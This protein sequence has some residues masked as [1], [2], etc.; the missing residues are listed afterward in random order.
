MASIHL[1]TVS[2]CYV[3]FH[4]QNVLILK[5]YKMILIEF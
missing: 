3:L 5:P 4:D 2:F 1:H